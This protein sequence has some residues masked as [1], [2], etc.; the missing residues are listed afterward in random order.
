M[1]DNLLSF[2]LAVDSVEKDSRYSYL[3]NRSNYYTG[4]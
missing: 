1:T 3:C 2:E 4:N